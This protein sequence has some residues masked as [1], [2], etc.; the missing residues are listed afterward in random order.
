MSKMSPN[1][2]CSFGA[3]KYSIWPRIRGGIFGAM[4]NVGTEGRDVRNGE[5]VR[6]EKSKVKDGTGGGS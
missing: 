6:S 3:V 5:E 1:S 2:F 4:K